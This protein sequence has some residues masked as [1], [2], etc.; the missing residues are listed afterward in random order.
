M[1]Q[2]TGNPATKALEQQAGM[3]NDPATP[4]PTGRPPQEITTEA[5][6]NAL[7]SGATYT[8]NGITHKKK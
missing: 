8:N 4:P 1:D 5:A 6:Y 3:G 7:P 2:L